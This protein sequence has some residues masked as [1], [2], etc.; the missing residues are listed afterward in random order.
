MKFCIECGKKL[1]DAAKFCDGC[2]TKVAEPVSSNESTSGKDEDGDAI[3]TRR[4]VDKVLDYD[5][6]QKVKKLM[7]TFKRTVKCDRI[8]IVGEDD[9]DDLV[10]NFASVIKE[11]GGEG[12]E[13]DELAEYSIA[14]IDNSKAGRG[15]RGTLIT[16]MGILVVDKDI[17][18]YE[19]D[20]EDEG[21]V[22]WTLFAKFGMPVDDENYSL[23]DV[24]MLKESEE[25]SKEVKADFKDSEDVTYF[26]RF[27]RTGLEA[28]Q[29]TELAEA[30]KSIAE[31]LPD[32]EDSADEDSGDEDDEESEG[33]NVVDGF[34]SDKDLDDDY[35][36]DGKAL[37]GFSSDK[38]LDDD[39]EDE[40]ENRGGLSPA[41]RFFAEP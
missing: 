9:Y 14:L 7:Q 10:R 20:A 32:V 16:P 1:P 21:C 11:R 33:K 24:C 2:G 23:L 22:P 12:E 8:H 27:S 40:D 13:F 41:G 18:N 15:K 6:A 3:I 25:V 36:E 5:A 39:D 35:E 28:E 34:S 29:V 17:P 26:L 4:D 30:L 37:D 38:D 19:E 31:N